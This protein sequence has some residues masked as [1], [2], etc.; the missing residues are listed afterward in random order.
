MTENL[1]CKEISQLLRSWI[2]K[3]NVLFDR[4]LFVVVL[5]PKS[6]THLSKTN[7]RTK[8]KY[9]FTHISI[10]PNATIFQIDLL[11]FIFYTLNK[12]AKRTFEFERQTQ[13]VYTVRTCIKRRQRR[14]IYAIYRV[15]VNKWTKTLTENINPNTNT[16]GQNKISIHAHELRLNGL[17]CAVLEFSNQLRSNH[18]MKGLQE[19]SLRYK[20]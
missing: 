1:L 20:M 3:M 16:L 4:F 11:F 12:T 5:C 19:K 10:L 15:W 17:C 8:S 2:L 9:L 18:M 6:K 14:K 7:Y 13:S